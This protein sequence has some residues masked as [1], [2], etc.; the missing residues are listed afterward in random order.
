MQS[1][2]IPFNLLAT[3]ALTL[4]SGSML[5]GGADGEYITRY[6][7]LLLLCFLAVFLRY[8]FSMANDKN[9]GNKLISSNKKAHFDYLLFDKFEAGIALLGTEIKSIRRNGYFNRR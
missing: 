2:E 6:G 8:T 4:V 5:A 9:Q 1:R 3:V 7:G